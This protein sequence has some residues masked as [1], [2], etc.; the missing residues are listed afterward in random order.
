MRHR[1]GG[2][3]VMARP[4]A[5]EPH[6][7]A[8]AVAGDVASAPP[9][10]PN[11]RMLDPARDCHGGNPSRPPPVLG[12]VAVGPGAELGTDGPVPFAAC[13]LPVAS[14]GIRPVL[15]MI[16][17]A[18][19]TDATVLVWGESGVGKELVARMLHA[20]SPRWQGP[21]VKV[22]CAALPL[23]LLESELFGYERGAFTGAHRQK[24][25]KY[26]LAHQG[27]IMLDEIGEIPLPL[28]AK[29]LHVLQDGEFSRLGSRRDIKVDARVIAVTN[30]D[31]AK[32]VRTGLFREDLY[33]R[34]NVISIHVPPLRARR[35]EIPLLVDRFLSQYARQ[36]SRARASLS[37]QTMRSF[38]EHSWPG[39]IRELE[40]LVKR[41]VVLDSEDWVPEELALRAVA[42]VPD[43]PPPRSDVAPA[44]VPPVPDVSE[45]EALGLKEI[46]R[47]AA[48][49]AERIALQ[50]MMERVHWNRGEAARR[51][52][53][54]YT[55]LL[56]KMKQ[57][58]LDR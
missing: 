14:A 57:H 9:L 10:E 36:Y 47:R 52:K 17:Q 31:L 6:E 26:E 19:A 18:A 2:R 21:F 8:A 32:L 13:A 29:L 15:A 33:Y 46:A 45:A 5:G 44:R 53:I 58:Q 43:A 35:D 4:V 27:T 48:R 3:I 16:E 38:M 23:E 50:A 1:R 7:R 49:E 20:R 34:I 39:N 25:G 22:N 11:L 51:L 54:S 55:A 24:P 12:A 30:K 28:Q 37:P 42:G 41:V 56:Y 40:N